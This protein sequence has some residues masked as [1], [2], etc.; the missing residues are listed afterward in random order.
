LRVA[1]LLA[2]HRGEHTQA[3]RF[4]RAS[5]LLYAQLGGQLNAVERRDLEAVLRL[6]SDAPR[7][8]PAQ[9]PRTPA[10]E[11]ELQNVLGAALT[12]LVGEEVRV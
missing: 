4:A 6:G 5:E 11:G 10:T 7:E 1:G 9:A 2:H 8:P 12:T 3:V